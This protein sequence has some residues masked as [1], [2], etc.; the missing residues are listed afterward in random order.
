MAADVAVVTWVEQGKAIDSATAKV[1]GELANR[2]NAS[3]S[4]NHT[5]R[6]CMYPKVVQYNGM[7]DAESA[8]S[9]RW[10]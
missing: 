3:W 8:N 2:I 5:R 9:F 10:K 6:L 1:S 7:E 4:A